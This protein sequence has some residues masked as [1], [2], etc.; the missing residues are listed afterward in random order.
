MAPHLTHTGVHDHGFNN[1]GTCG[2]LL[3]LMAEGRVP[4]NHWER[5]YYELALK[6]SGAVQ[7]AR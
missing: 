3:R 5:R 4:E 7:A 2:N 1:A 6:C